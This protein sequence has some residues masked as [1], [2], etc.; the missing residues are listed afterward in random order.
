MNAG[1]VHNTFKSNGAAMPSGGRVSNAWATC[2][3]EGDNSRKQLLIPHEVFESHGLNTKDLS[4]TDGLAS[5]E[6]DG[7]VTAHHGD[8]R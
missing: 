4:H 3:C 6:L 1:G 2:L 8:D 7:E 5:D